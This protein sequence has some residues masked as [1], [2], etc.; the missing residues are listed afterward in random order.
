MNTQELREFQAAHTDWCGKPLVVDGV[1]GHKTRWALDIAR[2]EPMRQEQVARACSCVGKAEVGGAN[3]GELQD[4]LNRRAG[5]P[6]G[7]PYCAAGASW[8]LSVPGAPE[9]RQASA[10]GLLRSLRRVTLIQPGDVGGAPTSP[11]TGHVGVVI[12]QGPGVVWMVE[13]NH[14]NTVALVLRST[15][16]L[17]FGTNLPILSMPAPPSGLEVVPWSY[18]NTR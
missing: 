9:V 3:R 11:T 5:V 7:S 1:L 13:F 18:E 16:G 15:Q 10:M 6:L 14:G 2:L 12:A 4:M 17:E 8:A